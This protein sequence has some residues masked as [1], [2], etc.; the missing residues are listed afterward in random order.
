MRHRL[1]N[2]SGNGC[3]RVERNTPIDSQIP[4]ICAWKALNTCERSDAVE[5]ACSLRKRSLRKEMYDSYY[6][7]IYDG[8]PIGNIGFKSY[9]VTL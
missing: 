4:L 6:R 5:Y 2:V 9:T 8:S 7:N 3:H 1:L